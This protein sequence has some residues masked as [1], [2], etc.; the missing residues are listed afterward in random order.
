MV[1]VMASPEVPQ[2]EVEAMV[3]GYLARVAR[4]YVPLAVGLGIF[5][6]V[7]TLVPTKSAKQGSSLQSFNPGASS[8]NQGTTANGTTPGA[9]ASGPGQSASTPSGSTPSNAARSDVPVQG[10]A[11]PAAGTPGVARSGVKCGPGVKQVPWSPYA[12]PC[13]PQFTAN[14]GGATSPGV[15]SNTITLVFR[16]TLSAEEKAAFAAVGLAAPGTD[17]QYLYDLRKYLAL[18]NKSYE[19]YGRQVVVKDFKGVGDNLEE[20][21]GRQLQGAQA[22]AATAKS[23]GAFMDIT[24]SPTLASTQPYEEDLAQEKIITIG[25]LGLPRS[26]FR[27]YAPWEYSVPADGT[28]GA[29]AAANALCQRTAGL[30]AVYAGD[31]L[32][33]NQKRVYGLINPENPVYHELGNELAGAMSKQC[34]ATMAHR[35][36]YAINVA[37]MSQQSTSMVAQMKVHGVTT[38][39]C[40]CDPV[41]E[42]PLSYNAD[43]QQYGPEWFAVGWGD[44]Q[45]RDMSPNQWKH[46]LSGEGT[47][48]PKAKAEWYSVWKVA[49]PGEEPKEKYTAVAYYMLAYTFNL[50]Q[51]AG[52]NLNPATVRQSAFSMP[53]TPRGDI[54]AWSGGPEAYSP[55][56][57]G[58]IGY[59]DPN[60]KSNF[61]G[62]A[63]AWI[64]CEGGKWF[65][66]SDPSAFAPANTQFHCFGK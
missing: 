52:P 66:Y 30:N 55:S 20:D 44:P 34:G 60:A 22:D 64:S 48:P 24:Q 26:W 29:V 45:G 2:A 17:D 59:W 15:S 58:Q 25:G 63:G 46:A 37:T 38:I 12:P 6:L 18:F 53:R 14:N 10:V 27:Q 47:T 54:G 62:K 16:R 36:E 35:E 23:L 19:L 28:T 11:L 51:R 33:Q 56:T 50:L 41:V 43:G 42:I 21:Q 65:P 4:R 8:G 13:V 1:R 9:V 61:D 5:L 3:R 7:V 31:T 49:A 57:E 32:Y 39:I 40:V